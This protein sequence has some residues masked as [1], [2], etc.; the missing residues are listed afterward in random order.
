MDKKEITKAAQGIIE[1][2]ADLTDEQRLQ[3]IRE[4]TDVYCYH[5]GRKH[6]EQAPHGG[7]CQCW[8]DE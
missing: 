5:C 2:M 6:S 1:I 3:F 7:S 8:N 4:L